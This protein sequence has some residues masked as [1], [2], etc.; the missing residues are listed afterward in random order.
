MSPVAPRYRKIFRD[1]S[2]HWFRTL[3]VVLSIAIGIFAVGTMLGGREILLREFAAD[4]SASV[5]ADVTYRSADFDDELAAAA[6][7]QPG[8]AEVQARRS[9]LFRYRRPD[10][11]EDRTIS[12][13][14]FRDYNDIR[15]NKVAPVGDGHWP[16][17]SGEIVL[18][19]SAKQVDDY[20]I[21]D[22]LAVETAGGET[23]EL[24]V[25]GFAHDINAM[26]AQFVGYE[27]GYVSLG[28]MQDLGEPLKY[29]Q[30]SFAFED[31]D[32]TWAESSRGAID[33]REEV[34]DPRGVQV[35]YTDVP[36]PG[37]HFLGDIFGALS[38]LLLALGGLAL[39]LSAFLVV[40]TVSAL[41]SQQVR[42]VGIM[43]AVGGSAGQL[44]R[45]YTVIVTVY[46][47]LASAV[48][49]PLTAAATRWFADFAGDIL[50]F[51]IT[52]YDPPAWVIIVELAVGMVVPLAAAAGPV[53]RG[54]N[55]SVVRAL[56][57]AGVPSSR[58]G[59][60]I[61]DRVLGMIRGLPRPV[62]L[63]LR[64][65]FLRKGRLAL[66]LSTLALA[67]A[68]VMA[69]WSVQA[70]IERT[71]TNL[72]SWWRY[73]VQITFVLPQDAEA[74]QD[75]VAS[76]AGVEATEAWPAYNAA[77]VRADGTEN[78]SFS[79]IG[80]DPGTDFVG[81]T[82]VE[83]RWL[84]QGDTDAIV[85]NTDARNAEPSL[86][87]GDRA[88]L[89]VMGTEE[90][91]RIVGV[92][93]GQL[94]GPSV[95]C[96]ADQLAEALGTDGV[97]RL[98]VRGESQDADS[99]RADVRGRGPA[100]RSRV[101]GHRGRHSRRTREPAA[102]VARHPGGL[103]RADGDHAR[104]GRD[105]RPDRHHDDQ[106]AREHSR[107]RRHARD[108]SATQGHLPDLRDRRRDRGCN[109]VASRR[110]SRVPD[111]PGLGPC[112]R[113]VDRR[114]AELHVLLDGRRHLARDDARDLGAR[115]HRAGVPGEPGE[116]ARRHL[117]RVSAGLRRTAGAVFR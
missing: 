71:I 70:T 53:R 102:R 84:E 112:S 17:A 113:G 30:L 103:P 38:L 96:N 51:R 49:L 4:R 76:V 41:M 3:L 29:N 34:F 110:H 39:G 58:F 27:T 11:D 93:K 109:R 7:E 48:G 117:V 46:G 20:A 90:T 52:S 56:N 95:Y 14:A 33:L 54:V 12:V 37:S 22:V 25:S 101:P 94:G 50:N 47:V 28:A 105:D 75:E 98:L 42:Q 67:S 26:P 116:R 114:T 13:E 66:T 15:V 91:W 111:Q 44:E 40:N 72:E 77:V 64:N 108:R 68:V 100:H 92:I 80:L 65:T 6:G 45:L 69:V 106:R 1:M 21:G 86:G 9:V 99:E 43:K 18:E 59:H 8:V 24:R 74:V 32:I 83:G 62:A 87:L 31:P 23:V 79:I 85:I 5:P 89:N 57:A 82:V 60:G 104:R 61:V 19:A 10:S 73:D 16:P 35:Y 2:S 115:F 88:T 55:M 63:A 81:P 97:T 36:E 107:D 78:Q